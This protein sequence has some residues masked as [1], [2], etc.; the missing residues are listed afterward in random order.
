[1]HAL[2]GNT[3]LRV[4]CNHYYD[5]MHVTE[6]LMNQVLES[7]KQNDTLEK[8]RFFDEDFEFYEAANRLLKRN[9]DR[10]RSQ[11]RRKRSSS[12]MDVDDDYSIALAFLGNWL[13]LCLKLI[14]RSSPACFIFN[15]WSLIC[16]WPSL[17]SN[18]VLR[19]L[20]LCI[21]KP[22]GHRGMLIICDYL[23]V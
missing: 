10:N 7:L 6:E 15:F 13:I 8:F 21:V 23:L 3:T 22:I 20:I 17:L 4:L 12:R 19:V 1:M 5:R 2:E 18:L 9:K 11:V 14:S 16:S